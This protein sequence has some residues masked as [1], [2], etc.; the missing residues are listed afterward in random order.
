[1]HAWILQTSLP[2]SRVQETSARATSTRTV[3]TAWA[4]RSSTQKR[5]RSIPP[6]TKPARGESSLTLRMAELRSAGRWAKSAPRKASGLTWSAPTSTGSTS[7]TPCTIY[8][9]SC[10]NCYTWVCP[11]M[12]SSKQWRQHQRL[13]L[14][15]AAWLVRWVPITVRILACSVL[16]RVMRTCVIARVNWGGWRD[17]SLRRRC[18]G[19]AC[20]TGR[21]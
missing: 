8:P 13:R 17:G 12:T 4:A 18:G 5:A 16:S 19:T 20:D 6:S 11:C 15:R 10:P 9:L 14:V 2:A 3:S 7:T 21:L 1:M